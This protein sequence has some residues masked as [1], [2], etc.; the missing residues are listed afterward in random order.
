MTERAALIGGTLAV[1]SAVDEGTE[2]ELRLPANIAYDTIPK[3]SWWLRLL[4]KAPA[5]AEGDAS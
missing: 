1:W 2:L 4:A 3:R 5:R